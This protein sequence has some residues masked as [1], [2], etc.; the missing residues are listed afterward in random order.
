MDRYKAGAAGHRYRL[1]QDRVHQRENHGVHA[2][3]QC[4]RYD[5]GGREPAVSKDPAQTVSH[6]LGNDPG[7]P[8]RTLLFALLARRFH[9]TKLNQCLSARLGSGQP[10]GNFHRDRLFQVELEFAV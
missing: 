6:V 4:E 8:A 5:D 10:R 9:T 1:E 2:N 3:P 7:P